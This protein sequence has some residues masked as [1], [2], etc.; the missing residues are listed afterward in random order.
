[1]GRKGSFSRSV[2]PA[3]RTNAILFLNLHLDHSGAGNMPT[4]A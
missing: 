1:M 2:D 4:A 3:N